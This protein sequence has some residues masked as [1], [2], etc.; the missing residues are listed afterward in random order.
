MSNK[1]IV[2]WGSLIIILLT[3]ICYIAVTK[4]EEIKFIN[5]KQDL[6]EDVKEYIK[7]NDIELPFEI[8]SEELE[9]QGYI[10]P[11]VLGNK[12]CAADIKVTKKFIFKKYD[13]DF[14]CIIKEE[15]D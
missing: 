15:T 14:T 4:K 6:K 12:L 5:L 1:I 11:I 10:K 9:E 13:I 3:M 2:L 7:D 8:T